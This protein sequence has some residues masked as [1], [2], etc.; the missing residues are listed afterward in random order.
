MTIA[1]LITL[2]TQDQR[3]NASYPDSRREV[4]PTLIRN[5]GTAEHGEGTIIYSRLDET[6]VDQVIDEQIAWFTARGQNFEWKAYDYDTPADLV[7][8]LAAHGF[9]IEENESIMVLDLAQAPPTLLQPV[10]HRIERVTAPEELRVVRTIEEAVWGGDFN[11]LIDFL[12]HALRHH[13]MRMSVYVAYAGDV[14]ASAAWIYYPTGSRFA[15]LWGGSTLA[16]YRGQGL[17]TALL[18][19][20]AQEA[21]NRHVDYLT[22]DASAMSRP[23]LEKFGFIKIAESYPCK[24]RLL[25]ARP[26]GAKA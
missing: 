1:E 26:T 16:A 18:A 15:S 12:G 3:I 17:Y 8:R 4:L 10:R 11:W 14:P 7:A 25:Q 5:V 13:P 9:V 22:V 6:N 23:I 20:R 2:Y 24:W 21:I 19:S